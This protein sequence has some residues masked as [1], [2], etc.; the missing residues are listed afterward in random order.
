[1]RTAGAVR[2]D[3]YGGNVAVEPRP[4]EHAAR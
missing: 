3:E 1:M 4:E 2:G